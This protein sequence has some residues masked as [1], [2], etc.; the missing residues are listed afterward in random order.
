MV[1]QEGQQTEQTDIVE[2]VMKRDFRAH[3][4]ALQENRIIMWSKLY[5]NVSTLG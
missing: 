1:A 4:V 3:Q 5:T 2:F